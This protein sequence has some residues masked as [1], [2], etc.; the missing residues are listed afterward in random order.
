MIAAFV[1]ELQFLEDEDE[2]IYLRGYN[3]KYWE[4]YLRYCDE[5]YV[6]GRKRKAANVEVK[7][8]D[9]FKGKK[10]KLYEVPSIHSPMDLL[11]NSR[12]AER[13]MKKLVHNV[14]YII[15][16]QPGRYSD[17]VLSECKKQQV[18]YLIEMV[19]CP[20]DSLWNHSLYGKLL[21]PLTVLKTKKNLKKAPYVVYVT[22]KFLQG[23]YPSNGVQTNCSNVTLPKQDE[24]ILENRSA[25]LD[26]F[27]NRKVIKIGT[28]AAVNVRYKGQ[29]YMIEALSTLKK[30]GIPDYEYHLVGGGDQ[31]YLQQ[32]AANLGV[33]DQVVFHGSLAHDDVFRFLD[34]L[35]LYIQPSLQ[36]GLPRALIEAM[37]R[38][39]P[40]LAA[41]TGGIPELL[42]PQFIFSNSRSRNTEIVNIIKGFSENVMREQAIRNFR[43]TKKY[44]A[45][46]ID[47]RRQKLF[48]EFLQTIK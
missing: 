8:L 39:L 4:R 34:G 5:L 22:E 24:K 30:Q 1:H 23:R 45:D 46:K 29:Q 3:K 14:D 48:L 42:E 6:V 47:S 18:P 10:L 15:T 38:G 27:R 41:K 31:S 2:N 37:S 13:L 43:E 11:S 26:G 36:E 35:D 28:I 12:K 9:V 19:G 17:K 20:W 16:R 32:I 7:G 21:A 40:C 33:A 44:E 25:F